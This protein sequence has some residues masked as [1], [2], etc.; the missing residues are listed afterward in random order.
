MKKKIDYA[1]AGVNID[2]ADAAKQKIKAMVKATFTPGV[3]SEIG[4]FGGFFSLEGQNYK[5]PV[6]VSSVDGVGTKLKIASLMNKYE[7]VGIDLVNHCTDDILVHGA[8]PLF[9]LDYIAMSKTTPKTVGEIVKGLVT[10]CKIEKCALI[11]GET[12]Q[13][14]DVYKGSDFDFVGLIVGIVEKNKIIDGSNIKAGDKIIGIKSTG[15]HTNGYTLARKLLL[16]KAGLKVSSY[17]KKLKTTVGKALLAPHKSYTKPVFRLIESL[18]VKGLAH[19]TGG[20]FT[21]NIP[22]ILPEGL[23]VVIEKKSWK[24]LPIFALMSEIGNLNDAEMYRTF[25][26]GV[27]MCIFVDDKDIN[28]ALRI[29][30]ACKEPGV[31]IGEV[32]KSRSGAKKVELV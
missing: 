30:K 6:F 22:R 19:I 26:M 27:G 28:K 10:A 2:I 14:P 11:G 3:L 17:V 1:S 8:K 21:D 13:M 25:N 23:S 4:K 9:M 5:N 18:D 7:T 31:V 32:V 12:A 16:E 29:L 20:G 15:L 24:P